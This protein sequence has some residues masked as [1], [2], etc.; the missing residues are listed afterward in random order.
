[1]LLTLSSKSLDD[2]GKLDSLLA[3]EWVISFGTLA[4]L[5]AK[6]RQNDSHVLS[7]MQIPCIAIGSKSDS[8]CGAGHGDRNL[9]R[10]R[11]PR[12]MELTLEFGVMEGIIRFLN[13]G[14]KSTAPTWHKLCACEDLVL[15]R[16][17][18]PAFEAICARGCA[19][20]RALGYVRACLRPRVD[21]A[22]V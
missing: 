16:R 8:A 14:R 22:G 12:L 2:V 19:C 6:R 11:F 3:A 10:L 4:M 20:V 18:L 21:S 7:N 13:H 9:E 15:G 5:L 17:R 1:M